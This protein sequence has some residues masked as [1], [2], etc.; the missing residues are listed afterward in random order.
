M[1]NMRLDKFLS[2]TT[3]ESRS[4][5]KEILKAGRVKVN[6]ETAKDPS[7][8]I[9]PDTDSVE[10]DSKAVVYE[11]FRYYMLNKPAGCVS[12]TKDKLSDTVLDFFRGEN[13]DGFFPVGRLDKDSEGLLLITNDGM[14][15]HNLL[16]PSG[17]VEKVYFVELDRKLEED[18]RIKI[19]NKIDIGDDKPC[20]P[21]KV[22]T[23]EN[24]TALISITEGRFHQVKRMFAAAGYE[25]KYLKRIAM[26]SLFLDEKLKPGEYRKLSDEDI[27]PL[28]KK[29]QYG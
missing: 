21:A 4:R 15:A 20:L 2:N 16:S 6:S 25:V 19:E 29:E 1:E 18:D 7:L 23:K 14:L 11:K 26:G 22:E 13:M 10:L 3:G 24:N 12:A 9:F 5:I 17:H 28:R 8:K 27:C